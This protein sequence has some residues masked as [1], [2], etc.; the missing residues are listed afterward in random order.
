MLGGGVVVVVVP[1]TVEYL[2]GAVGPPVL[3]DAAM[4]ECKVERDAS[5][6]RKHVEEYVGH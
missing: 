3:I 2:H 4:L 6:N 5:L 1:K